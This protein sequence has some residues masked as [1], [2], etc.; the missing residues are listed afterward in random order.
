LQVITAHQLCVQVSSDTM[1][2]FLFTFVV[3]AVACYAVYQRNVQKQLAGLPPLADGGYPVVGHALKIFKNPSKF[4]TD[5][6]Q[7]YG[8]I[9]MVQMLWK[10]HVVIANRD[11]FKDFYSARESALSFTQYLKYMPITRCIY[12]KVDTKLDKVSVIT[13]KKLVLERLD[14]PIR[15]MIVKGYESLP[16]S[17]TLDLLQFTQTVVG[18]I[19]CC[20]ALGEY[21][22]DSLCQK[23]NALEAIMI[24]TATNYLMYGRYY[25]DHVTM[26][27]VDKTRKEIVEQLL[28]FIR[29][30]RANPQTTYMKLLFEFKHEDGSPLSDEDIALIFHG[31][32]FAAVSTTATASA[33]T[34]LMAASYKNEVETLK[35]ELETVPFGDSKL[36]H[37]W[38][39]ETARLNHGCLGHTRMVA[40]KDGFEI[41]GYVLPAGTIVCTEGYTS[42]RAS[43]EFEDPT[44]FIPTRFLEEPE[45]E[46][47][48]RYGVTNWSSGRHL[49]PGKAMALLE[50][51]CFLDEGLK[52]LEFGAPE[53]PFESVTSAIDAMRRNPCYVVPF[54]KIN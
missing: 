8:D 31:L 2:P 1:L 53:K 6:K 14:E 34:L 45:S 49:C 43:N 30:A 54:K 44:V 50:M 29:A 46:Q 36:L 38:A 40:E 10:Y 28:P 41:C 35:Q 47:T 52:R 4:F 17:G 16:Q 20:I 48:K 25:I 27:V 37:S 21:V 12:G 11:H 51:K 22:G 5:A 39:L 15:D 32:Y 9:Y 26:P 7:K 33:N 18:R 19:I 23:M 24:K 13:A 3:L 42:S